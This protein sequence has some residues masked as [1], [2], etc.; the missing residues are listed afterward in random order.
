MGDGSAVPVGVGVLVGCDVEDPQAERSIS[1][2]AKK[3]KE[4]GKKNLRIATVNVFVSSQDGYILFE[5]GYLHFGFLQ[6]STLKF[7]NQS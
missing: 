1:K 3:H 2:I 6:Q 4:K 5:K 7:G